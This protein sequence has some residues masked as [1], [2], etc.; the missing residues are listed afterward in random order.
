LVSYGSTLR[1]VE[2]A[3]EELADVG[4]DA[5][6]IDAQT[7][8]PFDINHDVLKSLQKTNRLLVVDEDVPGGCSA[9]LMQEIVEKQGGYKFLEV[10]NS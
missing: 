6:V 2:K 10:T 5:E 7:L 4:I 9:Y 8:L 3:A 1:I